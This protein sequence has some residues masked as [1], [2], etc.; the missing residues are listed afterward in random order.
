M[1]KTKGLERKGQKHPFFLF[2]RSVVFTQ[3][4][5]EIFRASRSRSSSMTKRQRRLLHRRSKTRQK[6]PRPQSNEAENFSG[7]KQKLVLI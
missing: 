4:V 5:D 3:K 2:L 7:Q 1:E 6:S